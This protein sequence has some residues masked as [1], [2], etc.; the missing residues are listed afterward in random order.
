MH[1]VVAPWLNQ[2]PYPNRRL[3]QAGLSLLEVAMLMMILTLALAPLIRHLGGPTGTQG[4]SARMVGMQTKEVL[5]AN[6]LIEEALSNDY[7]SLN[8]SSTFD[9][10]SFPAVGA[11][12]TFPASSRCVNNSYNQP[13]YYQWVVNNASQVNSLLPQGNQY[14]NAVLNIYSAS[15]G[16]TP[17]LTMPASFF[18][19]SSGT[20]TPQNKTGIVIIQDISGSMVWGQ[21]DYN[22][23]NALGDNLPGNAVVASP[24][25]A[26]RYADPSVGYTPPAN[27][28]LPWASG[29]NANNDQLDIVSA[30]TTDDPSTPWN[31]VYLG[32]G[33]LGLG[34]G[35]GALSDCT[36]N[37]AW[38]SANWRGSQLY[39]T[40]VNAQPNFTQQSI[41]DTLISICTRSPNW[42]TMMNQNMSRIEAAR[43]SLLNFILS[44]EEDSTLYQNVKLGLETF[45]SP[46][47]ASDNDPSGQGYDVRVALESV[48]TNNRYPNMRRQVSWMN[49]EGPG[50]INAYNGTNYTAP[51]NRA[52][53]LLFSDT[54]LNNRIILLVSD[55]EPNGPGDTHA[56]LSNLATKIGNGTYPGSNAQKASIF[57]L[58]LLSSTPQMPIYLQ[59]DL[60]MHTPGGQYFEAQNVGDISGIFDQIKYQL[61]RVILLNKSNRYN[62]NF[63]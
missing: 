20:S 52:A 7:S 40:L 30:Q 17:I 8:C 21:Q 61:L 39:S 36:K 10:S 45:S 33:A 49:R 60:A 63:T 53:Q 27:I 16:G 48:D 5:L 37:N 14:Y 44:V 2:S 6:T 18:Y 58:G 22:L 42:N 19:N 51:I 62:I 28:A 41:R 43:G 34:T 26:Y 32:N 11:Y 12:A 13:L 38:S 56:Q 31:D 9:P 15:S 46:N 55:G 29:N 47:S 54:T 35:P 59:N 57:T 24:Y 25:L 3:R 4:N 1:P 23:I 50:Q